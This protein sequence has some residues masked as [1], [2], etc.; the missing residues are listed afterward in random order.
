MHRLGFIILVLMVGLVA[1]SCKVR[2]EVKIVE[3]PTPQTEAAPNSDS[4]SW[5]MGQVVGPTGF[6][7]LSSKV[8]FTFTDHGREQSFAGRVRVIEDSAIWLSVTP[9]MGIE[10]VRALVTRDSVVVLDR[11]NKRYMRGPHHM[12]DT[13]LGIPFSFWGVQAL[14]TGAVPFL[15]QWQN[16]ASATCTD[17]LIQLHTLR[18]VLLGPNLGAQ[19][20]I[21]VH[22]ASHWL[23]RSLINETGSSRSLRAFYS[24]HKNW[25]EL[26]F[27]EVMIFEAVGERPIKLRIDWSKPDF[28][29]PIE[30]PC[31]IP[32][33]YEPM[34]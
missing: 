18:P 13:M 1:P 12:F 14:I 26:V 15:H 20:G 5:W 16:N 9:L 29:Q 8:N 23:C 6:K 19:L 25:G 3:I 21:H 10:V 22:T 7:T 17:T 31:N 28:G 30:V 2:K 34:R 4:A 32:Q 33:G 27:P 24:G 11:F